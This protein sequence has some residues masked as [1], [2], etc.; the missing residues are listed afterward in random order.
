LWAATLTA[1]LLVSEVVAAKAARDALFLGHFGAGLL[2]QAMLG[3]SLIS[4]LVAFA[5]GSLL[6]RIGPVRASTTLLSV[7]ALAHLAQAAMFSRS[8]VTVIVLLYLQVASLG[9][10]LMSCF[11]SAVTER[12]D[13]HAARAAV[14]RIAAGASVGGLVGGLCAAPLVK[15][16]SVPVLLGA[17]GLLQSISAFLV[18]RLTHPGPQ[19]LGEQTRGGFSLLIGSGYLQML[20][21]IVA[22]TAL[23]STLLDYVLKVRAVSVFSETT[24]LLSFFGAFYTLTSVLAAVVQLF[25]TRRALEG[26]GLGGTL[27]SLPGWVVVLSALALVM[28]E[29]WPIILLRGGAN[30]LENSFYRSAYEP[31]YTPLSPEKKRAVKTI[32]DVAAERSG[33]LIG[34]GLVLAAVALLPRFAGFAALGVAASVAAGALLLALALHHGYVRELAKSLR[35]GVVKL[36]DTDVQDRTTRLTLSQTAIEID[37]DELLRQIAALRTESREERAALRTSVDA[38]LSDEPARIESALAQGLEP[39]LVPLALPLLGR[40]DLVEAATAALREVAPRAVGTLTDALLDDKTPERVRRRIPRVLEA[41]SGER[42][43][44]AL[45]DALATAEFE[46]R[47]RAGLALRSLLEREDRTLPQELI[48]AAVEREVEAKPLGPQAR[49]HVFT[50]LGLALDREPVELSLRALDSNDQ[51]LRGTALEYLDNVLP[52]RLREAILPHVGEQAVK[53]KGPSPR[54]RD[55]IV[56]ELK[57]SFDGLSL[58]GLRNEAA[59]GSDS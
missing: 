55:Q 2:P 37:R 46:V 32:L 23:M 26:V 29:L 34:A 49:E 11:W 51:K 13:P 6:R 58:A 33:D 43:L 59:G 27:A 4:L 15:Y 47:Y 53:I 10:V 17:F 31:L 21:G 18:G 5:V 52:A 54:P 45:T 25:V 12:F 7:S 3:A 28:P 48:F 14:T 9:A 41:A 57:R 1:G 50:L 30:V 38:L 39:A 16:T 44:S 8:P 20:G 24:Q 35:L 36:R 19:R 42:A 56:D 40:D 22:L